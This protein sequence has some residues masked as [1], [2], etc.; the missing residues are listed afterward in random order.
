MR[1]ECGDR[2]LADLYSTSFEDSDFYDYVHTTPSGA[3]KVGSRIAAF[4][5][6]SDLMDELRTGSAR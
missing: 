2:R 4:I 1:E 5:E 6:Q 3:R